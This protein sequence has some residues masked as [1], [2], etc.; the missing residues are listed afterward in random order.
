MKDHLWVV[1]IILNSFSFTAH[2]FFISKSKYGKGIEECGGS[3]DLCHVDDGIGFVKESKY[4]RTC[5][6]KPSMK[7]E[8]HGELDWDSGN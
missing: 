6:F 2:A 3:Q 8:D 5:V 1:G 4:I 7:Y